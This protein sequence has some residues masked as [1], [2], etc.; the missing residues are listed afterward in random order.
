MK[1]QRQRHDLDYKR[2]IVTEY[3]SGR[4]TA[5]NLAKREGL[6]RGQIY[7]WRV[8]VE[9]RDRTQRILVRFLWAAKEN[10]P[11]VRGRNPVSTPSPKAT[12]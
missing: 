9:R 12:P 10:E 7:K 11:V 3:L 8:Q 1:K 2:R 4:I 6:V 5:D